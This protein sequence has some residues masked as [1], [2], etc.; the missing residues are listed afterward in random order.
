SGETV[1]DTLAAVL[2]AEPDWTLLPNETPR[3]IVKLLKRCLEKD[4]RQR[5]RDIGE[6]RIVI[7]AVERGVD[8][9]EPASSAMGT[10]AGTKRAWRPW[11]P[12]APP[13]PAPPASILSPQ[14]REAP[15]TSAPL[16][17]LSLVLPPDASLSL[18]GQNPA[19]PTISPDGRRVVFGIS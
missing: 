9:E 11:S 10:R 7:E 6:A 1:S 12:P 15:A 18:R 2:R 5:L 19:P 8:I 14:Q 13:I 3:A 17:Q 16:T 4:P